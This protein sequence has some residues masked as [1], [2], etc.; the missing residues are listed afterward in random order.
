MK[1]T[2]TTPCHFQE[3]AI[4]TL[5]D[6][7]LATAELMPTLD[8][9]VRCA[10]CRAFYRRARDLDTA[11]SQQG[12]T[13]HQHGLAEQSAEEEHE[14]PPEALWERIAAASTPATPRRF[15]ARWLPQIAAALLLAFGLWAVQAYEGPRAESN[16]EG[17]ELVLGEDG[18]AMTEQRFVA[19]T[20]EV[21]RADRRYRELML[22]VM[23]SVDEA[24]S[25]REVS[26]D[27]YAP[28]AEGWEQAERLAEDHTTL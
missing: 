14:A 18:G 9:L 22:A 21:L 8:H 25:G 5:V 1:Q 4:S 27:E 17:I 20:A 26:A 3:L 28:R 12:L 16:L 11:V 23:R 10:A 15:E 7:E 6:G 2:G 24:D 19:L 13:E